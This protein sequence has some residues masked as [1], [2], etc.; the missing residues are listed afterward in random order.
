MD[1]FIGAGPAIPVSGPWNSRR[2]LAVGCWWLLVAVVASPAFAQARLPSAAT[3]AEA[4]RQLD[5]RKFPLLMGADEDADR[6]LARVFYR[7]QADVRGGFDFQ[8]SE[9]LRLKWKELAGSYL[10]DEVCSAAFEKDG[11]R[12]S[13]SV[14]QTGKPG[15]ITVTLTQH[16]NVDVAALPV[17]KGA[18]GPYDTPVSKAWVTEE[19]LEQTRQTISTLLRE[20]GWTPYGNAGDLQFFKQNAVRLHARVFAAPA[21]GNKTTIDYSAELMS[22]DLPAPPGATRVDYSDSQLS[23]DTSLTIAETEAFYRDTLKK[24]GWQAT[25]EQMIKDL[26][27]QFLI[28]RNPDKQLMQL[29]LQTFEGKSRGRLLLQS[30]EQVE[31]TLKLAQKKSSEGDTSQ[32]TRLPI[33]KISLPEGAKNIRSEPEELE[34]E[35]P[36][37]K[38]R[39]VVS[40]WQKEFTSRG[41]EE[42]E[43]VLDAMAGV[44]VL[45]KDLQSLTITYTDTR[46]LPA[47]VTLS[48]TG[49][50]LQRDVAKSTPSKPNPPP[51][52]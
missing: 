9:L 42:L 17:P 25:T 7:V 32:P 3:V 52:K 37:G 24:A 34:F 36:A 26:V 38:A 48:A 13:V 51:K 50:R 47:T 49:C 1:P 5:L 45:E 31:L 41:W 8:R 15:E 35:L 20:R 43:A 6:Q 27:N 22:A 39:G 44:V 28:F 10:T 11:F 46:V 2:P 19:P 18:K 21:Q 4:A 30:A 16:G 14:S 29:E 23:F 40:S 33:V 12:V